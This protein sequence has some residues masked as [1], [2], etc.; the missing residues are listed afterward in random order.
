MSGQ[1]GQI[2]FVI[3]RE[4][5]E[6]LLVVGILH[7]WL[8]RQTDPATVTVGRRYLWSGVLAG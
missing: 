5:V 4:S 8:S 2:I 1:F 3:W 7:A 6:P